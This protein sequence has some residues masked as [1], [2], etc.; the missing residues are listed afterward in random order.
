[1]ANV[2][3]VPLY[4]LFIRGQTIKSYSL[5][6]KKCSELNYLIPLAKKNQ[7]PYIEKSKSSE[8]NHYR[9]LEHDEDDDN[10]E[11]IH[12]NVDDQTGYKGAFVFDPIKGYH[13]E[14]IIVLD[15]SSLYPSCIIEYNMSLETVVENSKYLNLSHIEYKTITFL[16]SNN[17][18]IECTFAKDKSGI[19]G[20]TPQIL[21]ELLDERNK[22]KKDM[23]NEK[24]AFKYSIL[25]GRQL[26]LKITAN[27]I[28][29]Q[30]G[31]RMSPL[32][33]KQ[34]AGSTTAAGRNRLIYAKTFIEDILHNLCETRMDTDKF[35][36]QFQQFIKL[37]KYDR[38][39]KPIVED[40]LCKY[41][42][43][44]LNMILHDTQVQPK[45]IYG[46][47]DSTFFP[48]NIKDT[49][50]M[51]KLE[52]SIKSGQ[53]ISELMNYTL[54]YPHKIEYEKTMFPF[55]MISKKRYVGNLY[56]NDIH[57][58]KQKSM[59]IVLKR[60]DNAPIVKIVCGGIVNVLLN[61]YDKNAAIEYTHRLLKDILD[62]KYDMDKFIISKTLKNGYKNRNSIAH[63]VLYDRIKKREPGNALQVNDRIP[64]AFVR[65]RNK[66][67]LQGDRIEHPSYILSHHLKIDYLYYIQ[68]QI[69][70]PTLQFLELI[71]ENSQ[72]IFQKYII[73]ETNKQNNQP[74]ITQ[75]FSKR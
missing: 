63:A 58:Y 67:K 50:P 41:V 40:E 49:E 36:E 20:I 60:R 52:I 62:G 38:L 18:E 24:D 46:D 64:Y 3:S 70:K 45:V 61:K 48:L 27:S 35:K 75:F 43:D 55:C 5:F 13:I 33:C 22:T 47:T 74:M 17:K 69:M 23:K 42:Q 73:L 31:A 54:P 30:H 6:S 51:K 44:K 56:E 2:C 12:C 9:D 1:M 66:T 21:L 32:Y 10:N 34:I 53:F 8:H 7:N 19:V 68:H 25:N 59:G 72:N 14:P 57:S 37:L 65:T 26:A 11:D 4:Y 15:Y 39:T 71:C 28:Y 29:G 16:D